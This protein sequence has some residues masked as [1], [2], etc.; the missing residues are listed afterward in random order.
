M[1]SFLH[2]GMI[3][4][5]VYIQPIESSVENIKCL[6]GEIVLLAIN[7][8]NY[9]LI[10]D[11]EGDDEILRLKIGWAIVAFSSFIL[12]WHTGQ[13]IFEISKSLLLMI[14]KVVVYFK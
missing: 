4:Y 9:L 1:I 14:K 3:I 13:M 2:I 10:D 12:L 11:N 7:I 8:C 6:S 5:L